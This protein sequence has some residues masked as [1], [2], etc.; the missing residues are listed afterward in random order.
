[1][2][3]KGAFRAAAVLSASRLKET[4]QW[5]RK[6]SKRN[7]RTPAQGHPQPQGGRVHSKRGTVLGRLVAKKQEIEMKPY[8]AGHLEAEEGPWSPGQMCRSKGWCW[9]WCWDALGQGGPGGAQAPTVSWPEPVS[10]PQGENK[11]IPAGKG[12][13]AAWG[14]QRL[15]EYLLKGTNSEA[16]DY[17]KSS[18]LLCVIGEMG[19]ELNKQKFLQKY[20]YCHGWL[21][22]L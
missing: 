8:T 18:S 1:M 20:S 9:C 4:S 19:T 2:N 15:A 12:K 11:V 13:K 16:T 7:L 10:L 21:C 22:F 3:K 6:A 14:E 17:V 5:T